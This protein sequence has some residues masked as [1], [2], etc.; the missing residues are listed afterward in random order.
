MKYKYIRV[1][2]VPTKRKNPLRSSLEFK[3][4]SLSKIII[5]RLFDKVLI[6]SGL[7]G[8]LKRFPNM[9]KVWTNGCKKYWK[10]PVITILMP[11]HK[12]YIREI[13]LERVRIPKSKEIVILMILS[14]LDKF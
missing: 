7:G 3:W 5:I 1:N 6:Y 10:W 11:R 4:Q 14:L 9:G 8:Q 13:R 12:F 2:W